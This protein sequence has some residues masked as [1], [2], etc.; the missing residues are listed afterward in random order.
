MA[1]ITF[2][3]FAGI[4]LEAD[5]LGMPDDPAVLLLH[6]SGETRAMWDAAAEALVM[7]GR[8][9]VRLDLRGH[10]ASDRPADGR[11]DR[12]AYAEDIRAVLAQMAARPVIVA[13]SLGA[14]AAMAALAENGAHL[15]AA[16][17]LVDI[18]SPLD[19]ADC[20]E[21]VTGNWDPR[22]RQGF[23]AAEA[24][25]WLQARG[26]AIALPTLIVGGTGTSAPLAG[27]LISSPLAG[28]RAI[29][30]A[31]PDC[32]TRQI[33][34]AEGESCERS[35]AF[36]ALLL[37][38][39]ERRVPREPLAYRSGSDPRTLRDALGCFATGV[40]IIT[41]RAADG[42]PVG[43]TAN[44]FTSVSLDPPLLLACIDNRAQS[45]EALRATSHFAVN[46]LH[47]GQQPTSGRFA[48]RTTEDRFSSV[49]W[50]PGEHGSPIISGSLA[51]FE[52]RRHAIHEGGDHQIV[53]GEVLK[54]TFEPRRDPLLFFRGRYRRLHFG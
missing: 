42:H 54:A 15:A 44:S 20:G 29:L 35:D 39:L 46:V 40:T 53:V 48:A 4:R 9:V 30:N 12:E 6:G 43:L 5:Q 28:V 32:E 51:A 16:L 49:G 52:C 50:H 10:G 18:P 24:R 47:I 45:L 14:W 3:G 23:G 26:P 37:E 41:C 25:H 27:A 2:R 22:I 34:Q 7:A 19:C 1:V 17:V 13:S 38:F 36:S 21:T 33:D 31:M 8:S 11:Y